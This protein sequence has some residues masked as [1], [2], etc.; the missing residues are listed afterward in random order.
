MR[1]GSKIFLP[2]AVLDDDSQLDA[3]ID[4]VAE[5]MPRL[6]DGFHERA[7][8]TVPGTT[9]VRWV[10]V[11]L[12]RLDDFGATIL[13]QLQSLFDVAWADRIFPYLSGLIKGQI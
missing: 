8:E 5:D 10:A 3:Y 1:A 13:E 4:K 6:A 12:P 9:A 2:R 7:H 11:R